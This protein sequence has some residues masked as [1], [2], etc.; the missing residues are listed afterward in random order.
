MSLTVAD[1]EDLFQI[2]NSI[3][4]GWYRPGYMAVNNP[5]KATTI[6]GIAAT[7]IGFIPWE[8]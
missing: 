6:N 5:G 3:I 4:S 1:G 7:T 2:K 8:L